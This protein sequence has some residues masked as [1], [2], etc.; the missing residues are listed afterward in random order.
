MS[1]LGTEFNDSGLGEAGRLQSLNCYRGTEQV[2]KQFMKT[3]RVSAS[4][5]HNSLWQQGLGL[6]FFSLSKFP[7]L[8]F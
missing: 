6:A 4:F 5:S 1:D 8:V 3:F 2:F 7:F